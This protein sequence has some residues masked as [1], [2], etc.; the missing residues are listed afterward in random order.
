MWTSPYV[1]SQLT[2]Q[3]GNRVAHYIKIY[4]I[5]TQMIKAELNHFK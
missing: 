3:E 5:E 1:N 4:N 2:K